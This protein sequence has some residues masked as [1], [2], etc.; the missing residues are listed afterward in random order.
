[1]KD[2]RKDLSIL[3]EDDF[4]LFDPFFNNIF[5]ISPMKHEREFNHL[6]KTDIKEDENSYSLEIE[7]PGYDKKDINLELKDGY[8]SVSA[9]REK[10]TDE[11]DK[12]G[13][14]VKRERVFGSVSRTYFVGKDVKEEDVKA[15]LENGMLNIFVPKKK[16]ELE[17]HKKIEID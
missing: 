11:K 13:N 4:G 7:M 2:E 16:P 17:Q 1:M 15:K 6:M 5:R 12:K 9:K 10:E 14:Y 8:L 3:G